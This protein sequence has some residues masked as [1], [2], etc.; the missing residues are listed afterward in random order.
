[1]EQ[2]DASEDPRGL[3][4]YR[5]SRL[6]ALLNPLQQLLAAAPPEAALASPELLV[7]HRGMRDWLLQRLAE[8]AGPRG[9]VANLAIDTPE[10]WLARLFREVLEVPADPLRPWAHEV[11]RWRIHELLDGLDDSRLRRYL[12]DGSAET[13]AERRF[14][15]AARLARICTQYLVYRPDWLQAWQQDRPAVAGD[16]LLRELWRRLVAGTQSPHRAELVRRLCQRLRRERPERSALAREPLHVFGVAH[17]APQLLGVLQQLARLRTVV[18]YVPDPCRE[19]WTGLRGRAAELREA[20]RERPAAAATE[21]L[22][23]RQD[24]PLLGAW[25]R[26]G[27]HFMLALDEL[28]A[29]ADLR[30]WEDRGDAAPRSRLQ[31]LQ[32]SIRR[33]DFALLIGRA[34]GLREDASL[35]VHACHTRLRELEV[36]RDALLEARAARPELRPEQILVMLARVDAYQPLLPAVFG[37][38]GE[39]GPLPWRLVDAARASAHPLFEAFRRLLALPAARLSAAELADFLALT[40]VMR[41]LGIDADELDQLKRW[42]E[43]SRAGW[44][45]DGAQRERFGVPPI[46]EHTMAWASE[47]MLAGYLVGAGD[48]AAPL[49]L[50]LG[51]GEILRIAPL[52]GAEGPQARLLGALDQLLGELHELIRGA[53]AARRAS[54]WAAWFEARVGALFAIDYRDDAQRAAHDALQ[55]MIDALRSEPAAS[56]LDPELEFSVVRAVLAARL[57]A[58]PDG[59]AFIAGGITFCGM[60]PQRAIPFEVIA[61]LGLNDGEFPRALRDGGLDLMLEHPRMGDREVRSDDRYL[62]LESLMSARWRLHLSYLGQGVHDGKL[63]N[64]AAPLAELMEALDGAADGEPAGGESEDARWLRRRPWWVRHPLQPFDARYF[65]GRDAALFSHRADFAAMHARRP[66][67]P[68]P[69]AEAAPTAAK[70]LIAALEPAEQPLELSE[71]LAYYRDPAQQL[72]QRIGLHLDALGDGQLRE[73]EPLEARMEPIDQV[74]RRVFLELLGKAEGERELPLEPPEWLRCGGLLPPGRAGEEAWR[75]ERERLASLLAAAGDAGHPARALFREPLAPGLPVAIDLQLD[76]ARLRGE[77]REVREQA[78]ARWLLAVHPGKRFDRLDFK[79]RIDLFL[80]WAA[81]RLASGPQIAVRAAL[82]VAPDARHP[83]D[84]TPQLAAWDARIREGGAQGARARAE[85]ERRVAGLVGFWRAAQQRPQWYFPK[86]SWAA[87]ES[88][89]QA[90]AAWTGGYGVGERDYAPGYAALLAGER[91]FQDAGDFALLYQNAAYLAALIET[92]P[93]KEASA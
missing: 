80:R 27:Q 1:M 60:V 73:S 92:P 39:R 21:G 53:A 84:W 63:R 91:D 25:G 32:E 20:L 13:R 71:V 14:Q 89:E 64:P 30:H 68:R 67:S 19:L 44:A 88:M 46:A 42:L 24:H 22:F 76:R 33:E 10:A 65:D 74:A 47:R 59:Q 43:E 12:A 86:T 79:A 6:E 15:L 34:A 28:G 50:P 37:A 72:L 66:E 5:A 18:L 35:R 81:L 8:R 55:E 29:R 54:D 7:A 45:L 62:F 40:P 56:G 23:L 38:P 69:F 58:A 48:A 17:L 52:G 83:D 41:R 31:A 75:D 49:C 51:E 61:V 85:L 77:L 2:V 78:G 70:K 93:L 4:I 82:L 3:L 9:V 11:L 36:L 90:V 16:A 57:D 87:L 26:L